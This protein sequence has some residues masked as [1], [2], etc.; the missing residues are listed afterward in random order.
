M[1]RGELLD[2][3]AAGDSPLAEAQAALSA[4]QE[5]W[6]RDSRCATLLKTIGQYAAGADID[7]FADRSLAASVAEAFVCHVTPMLAA[8]P[9]GQVPVRYGHASRVSSM[10]LAREGRAM[11]SLV[12]R[13]P[14]RH[15]R[16]AVGFDG[17]QRHELVLGGKGAGR[18]VTR[19]DATLRFEPCVL[20]PA[21]S[22]ALDGREKALLVDEVETRLVSLRIDLLPETPIAAREY[23]IETG[24]FL[25]QSTGDAQESREELALAILGRMGRGDAVPLMAEFAREGSDHLRWQALREC[26]ALDTAAGMTLLRAI[27][28]NA[29]DSLNRPAAALLGELYA[30]HPQ[31]TMLEAA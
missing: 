17:V 5:A 23:S 10:L 29:A 2:L 15:E 3:L 6:R 14:G 19:P 8:H 24:E 9:L 31:L 30:T 26:I 20:Q 16:R 18:V 12:A 21:V 4:A 13:E 7:P 1:R 28:N 22:L 11:L 27:A 25:H